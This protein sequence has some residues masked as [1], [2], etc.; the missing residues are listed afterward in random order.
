MGVRSM[1][2]DEGDYIVDMAV[3]KEGCEVVTVS[4]LGYGKRSDIDAYRLQGRAGKGIK[5]GNFNEETGKLINLKL[6]SENEDLVIIADNGVMI[7]IR[8]SGISKIGR[9]TKGVRLMRLKGEGKVAAVALTPHE[10]DAEF[11]TIEDD[12]NDETPNT[13]A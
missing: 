7:R 10:E 2:L 5:A 4:E 13:E 9:S 8:A 3:I 11:D 12:G 6:V 1:K